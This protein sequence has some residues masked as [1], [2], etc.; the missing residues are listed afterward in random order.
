MIGM[1]FLSED[2]TYLVGGLGI[3]AGAFLIA[4]RVTQQGKYLVWALTALGFAALALV[5]E[6]LWVTEVER[7]E[8]VVYDL[9]RAVLASDVGGVLKHLTPDV[10]YVT[11]GAALPGG[12]TREL[13]RVNLANSVFD[14]VHISEL[15]ISAGRQTRRGTAAFRVF[16]K[17]T[18]K[19][20]LA[21]YNVGTANST[22]SLGFQET[23]PGVWKVNR[24][25][26]V[27]VPEGVLAVPSRGSTRADGEDSG[28]PT[29]KFGG[30]GRRFRGFPNR[31]QPDPTLRKGNQGLE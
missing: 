21:T 13:I 18:L 20:S 22:W 10:Q 17:G 9:R 8:R 5:F 19:T 2:S 31:T 6:Q 26:P 15:Q 4:L 29:K 11:D 24:I 25:T 28:V 1:T 7:I 14:L 27:S 30:L 12:A 23:E 3:M 16:A